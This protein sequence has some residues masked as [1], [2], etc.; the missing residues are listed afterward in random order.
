MEIAQLI[1]S[2]GALLKL[3]AIVGGTGVLF[4]LLAN[5][6]MKATGDSIDAHAGESRRY[7][8]MGLLQQATAFH[9][10]P[11][12]IPVALGVAGLLLI[13]GAVCMAIASLMWTPAAK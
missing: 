3:A 11:R 6:I 8:D 5:L 4:F 9:S 13:V 7:R 2:P 10:N 1:D 12:N